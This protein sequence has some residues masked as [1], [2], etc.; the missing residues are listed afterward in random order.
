MLEHL[1]GDVLYKY[2]CLQ[3]A[4]IREQRK[5]LEPK[6][7]NEGCTCNLAVVQKDDR[8]AMCYCQHL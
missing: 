7:S 8:D 5:K 4:D 1:S 3:V 2:Q 6:E